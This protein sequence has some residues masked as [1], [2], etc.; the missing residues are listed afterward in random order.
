MTD[1]STGRSAPRRENR[2]D[3]AVLS[4]EVRRLV[5]VLRAAQGEAPRQNLVARAVPAAG[6]PEHSGPT[7]PHPSWPVR[8]FPDTP[9]VREEPTK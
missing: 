3:Q 5:G 2:H 4:G 8:P 6:R 9:S 7:Q 1:V